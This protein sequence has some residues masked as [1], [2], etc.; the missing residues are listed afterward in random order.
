MKTGCSFSSL[1]IMQGFKLT[2]TETVIVN[3]TD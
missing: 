2:D 1:K 3:K